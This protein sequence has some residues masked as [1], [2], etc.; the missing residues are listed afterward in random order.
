MLQLVELIVMAIGFL[1]GWLISA[2]I[3][4]LAGRAVSGI[5]TTFTDALIVSLIG[6][7]VTTALDWV[8]INFIDPMF[9]AIPYWG[10][11]SIIVQI[12]IVLVVY[13]PLIMKFF[14]TSF[15]GAIAVG[16][17]VIVITVVIGIILGG[18]IL[19][20]VLL[21]LFPGP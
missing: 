8:F 4:W 11:I 1:I 7:I 3:F 9:A 13:I 10:I 18:I 5:N 15:W 14:D 17:L 12:I 2:F 21:L 6:T 19:A 16:L 20:I